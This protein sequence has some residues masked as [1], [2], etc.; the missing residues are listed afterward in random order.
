MRSDAMTDAGCGSDADAADKS[1]MLTEPPGPPMR[2]PGCALLVPTAVLADTVG[3]RYIMGRVRAMHRHTPAELDAIA[4]ELLQ[5]RMCYYMS[6][7]DW[8]THVPPIFVGFHGFATDFERSVFLRVLKQATKPRVLQSSFQQNGAF[9]GFA[10]L[11]PTTRAADVPMIEELFELFKMSAGVTDLGQYMSA[12]MVA[13]IERVEGGVRPYGNF[14]SL[15]A[16][17]VRVAYMQAKQKRD[18]AVQLERVRTETGLTFTTTN[19][20]QVHYQL[21][22][23][24]IELGQAFT[25]L[26][27]LR[28]LIGSI[29]LTLDVPTATATHVVPGPPVMIHDPC[30]SVQT[31][32]V[33]N[34]RTLI[35]TFINSTS[36]PPAPAA[37][38][39]VDLTV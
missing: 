28:H 35:D 5:V 25:L 37:P 21:V 14:H 36:R 34:L 7:Q 38:V 2:L 30:G 24:Q 1:D 27:R 18:A 32:Y 15:R 22:N 23:T 16:G 12:P 39:V 6:R 9:E 11:H 33:A 4:L 19:M 31:Q 17:N 20:L 10:I 3:M 8:L 13:C 26:Y 29:P